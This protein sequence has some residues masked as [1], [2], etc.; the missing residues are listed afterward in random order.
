MTGEAGM[1]LA[2]AERKRQTVQTTRR[3]AVFQTRSQ[4]AARIADRTASQQTLVISDCLIA[5]CTAPPMKLYAVTSTGESIR[6][7]IVLILAAPPQSLDR[8]QIRICD[9]S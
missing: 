1:S 4:A 7:N 8:I 9:S 2:A 5:Y 3:L 6:V